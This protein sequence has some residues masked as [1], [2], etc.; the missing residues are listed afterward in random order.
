MIIENIIDALFMPSLPVASL[1]L[2]LSFRLSWGKIFLTNL[3]KN[4]QA[5]YYATD[6]SGC[7]N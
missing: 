1:I 4:P 3:W 5:L 6:S 2:S 7:P